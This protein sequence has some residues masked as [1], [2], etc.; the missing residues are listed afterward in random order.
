MNT[1]KSE[2]TY[3]PLLSKHR[4]FLFG[5]A[6]VSVILLHSPYT[7]GLKILAFARELLYI[8][9]DIFILLSGFGIYKSLCKND[10]SQYVY[11]RLKRWYI[12][13]LPFITV[14][15]IVKNFGGHVSFSSA[16]GN[17]TLLGWYAGQSYQFNWYV[18]ALLVLYVLAPFIKDIIQKTTVIQNHLLVVLFFVI[19]INFFKTDFLLLFTR[20]PLFVL[21]MILSKQHNE[22]E[23][24]AIC[25][26]FISM[27]AG[28]GILPQYQPDAQR[29]YRRRGDR[30]T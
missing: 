21:G 1:M 7:P 27:I 10:L 28:I 17:L 23:P 29:G 13:Y 15:L 3:L 2:N 26:Y 19:S 20:I 30:C 22:G 16:F 12:P 6:I 24:A 8:G 4:E 9:V 18:Q 11:N 5:V 14:W 25:P